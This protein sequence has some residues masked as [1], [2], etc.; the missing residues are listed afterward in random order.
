M[1]RRLL[2]FLFIIFRSNTTKMFYYK[3]IIINGE[4]GCVQAFV[5]SK[6]AKRYKA[7]L[8]NCLQ[9][10]CRNYRGTLTIPYCCRIQGF[11]CD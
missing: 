3:K 4:N 10:G 7:R 9:N 5:N 2:Q 1:I 11:S 8:G 6:M